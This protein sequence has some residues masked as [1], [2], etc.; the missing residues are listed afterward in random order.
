MST[1]RPSTVYMLVMR[2]WCLRSN[3]LGKHL[4]ELQCTYR[5]CRKHVV[6]NDFKIIHSWDNSC[7]K[8]GKIVCFDNIRKATWRRKRIAWVYFS[9]H[10][11]CNYHI[12]Y[13]YWD[14]FKRQKTE[15]KL[16]KK[17]KKQGKNIDCSFANFIPR[18]KEKTPIT[19]HG[20]INKTQAANNFSIH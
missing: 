16:S 13:L 4:K 18:P 2:M 15:D 5:I 10:C 11:T 14:V 12:P 6:I 19:I 1:K 3:I 7:S 9:L 17:K 8:V 20:P